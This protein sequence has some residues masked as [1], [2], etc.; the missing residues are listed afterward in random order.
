MTV[1]PKLR[2]RASHRLT[3]VGAAVTALLL[4][5][6]AAWWWLFS[7]L[8]SV[9]TLEEHAVRPTTRIEDRNGLLL[10]EVVDP[11]SGKQINLDLSEIPAACV[12]ATLAT[13]DKR[14]YA[15]GGVDLIAIGRAVYQ[16]LRAGGDVVSGGS[17]ITQQVARNLLLPAE[18][19]YTQSLT[20]KLREAWLATLIEVH[21]TK[22]Q[23]LALYFNQTYYG[24]YAFG[25]EAAAQVFFGKP[26]HEL[27]RSE[28]ALLVGLVQY[29]TGYNPLVEPE[30]A[31][32]RQLTVLRLMREAGFIDADQQKAIAAEPLR[33]KSN[34]F[35]IAAPHFVMQVQDELIRRFGAER[36]R[37]GGLTVRTT[38]DLNLQRQ[39]EASVRH[40]LDLLNCRV[41][42]LCTPQTDPNRRVDNAAVVVLDSQTGDV[43]A[44]V[45]SPDY[46]D[47]A[48][49]GN[50]DAS[51]TLR[52]PGSAIKPLTYAFA[53]DPQRS[54]SVG[55]DPLTPAT[56]IPDLPA[57]FYV[58]DDSGARVPYSPVNYDRK[59]HG[60]VSVR[61]ALANSYNVPAVKV[62]ERIGVDSLK[63]IAGESGITTFNRDYGL[64]LTLGGGE[65]RLKELTAAFGILDDGRRLDPRSI[66]SINGEPTQPPRPGPQ[67]IDP[68]TAWLITDILDDDVARL[69][70]FGANSMLELPFDAAAK[71]GTTTDW[72]DNW[73]IGY[74]TEK[75]VG[76]WVGN[77]D[78]APMLDVSGI[79]G[80]GPIWRDVMLAAHPTPPA[81]FARPDGIVD[82][83]ICAPSGLLATPD[84]PRTRLEHFISGTEPTRADDQFR[85]VAIDKATGL[86]ATDATP[87]QRVESRVFW[88]LPAEY[89]DWQVGQGIAIAPPAQVEANGSLARS[90]AVA[91]PSTPTSQS[92]DLVLREP[93]A[94]TAYQIHPGVSRAQQ[95]LEVAG[96]ARDG[97]L[98]ADLRV[99][100]VGES[101]ERVVAS[102][103][104]ASRVQGWW[105][106]ETG[107]WHFRLEGR[108]AGESAW[109]PTGSALVHVEEY[110]STALAPQGSQVLVP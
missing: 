99:V 92:G 61:T 22:D 88:E 52:Q 25:L 27:A 73:T 104:D 96:F 79:D 56:I 90:A 103:E 37:E 110:A 41:Q 87:A 30:T 69:P 42:G 32:A 93:V 49:Q 13:E 101:G 76:V 109:T 53:M 2:M 16:N 48:T 86:R 54:A 66:L 85:R 20:R 78:N 4:V 51:M 38:L 70:A 50:V 95:R 107:D 3:L 1:H 84:C 19:R 6:G 46:F 58:K 43:L 100:A 59:S 65:V 11:D 108:R 55:L 97:L 68:R 94:N 5:I 24:N 45:G 23:I 15:H 31:K 33:Y 9:R 40:R 83:S 82:A 75:V 47:E 12:Q 62:L 64:A 72:R 8:P 21:Y 26:A 35:A 102:A 39:A 77:A 36:L 18:E 91:S 98:W 60:P 34:L 29:P 81:P 44:L 80:A 57:V 105:P 63:R 14:Y 74:T 28:C 89:H 71:T 7:D 17:T 106:L 67:V 10:Y